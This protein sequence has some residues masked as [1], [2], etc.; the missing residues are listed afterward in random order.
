MG[1]K[2]PLL[3]KK[4]PKRAHELPY[5]QDLPPLDTVIALQFQLGGDKRR[6]NWRQFILAL[7]L[8]TTKEME[9]VGISSTGDFLGIAPSYTSIRDPILR[10]CHKLIACSIAGRSQAPE[11]VTVTNLFYLRGMNVG[12]VNVPYLLA[13]YLRLFAAR[14]KSGA[15]ISGGQF[16]ARLAEHFGLLTEER[17][18]AQGP[19]RQPDASA[20][21]HGAVEDAP[22]VDE[23]MPQAM[24]PPPKTRGERIAR[25]VEEV[26][27]PSER[28]VD[29]Y[30]WGIY[31]SGDLKVLES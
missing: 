26:H 4:V 21:A 27:G 30:W 22:A 25:L 19:E 3:F 20:G 7:R 5:G 12:S 31:K 9:P 15:L 13:R 1:K 2:C 17:L 14:K 6:M 10:L 23:D 24:P 29:E 18:R 28:N 16:V 8:H 11:K